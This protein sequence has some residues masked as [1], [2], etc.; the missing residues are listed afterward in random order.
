MDM[1]E[2][3]LYFSCA[4][5]AHTDGDNKG[6]NDMYIFDTNGTYIPAVLR[7]A[8]NTFRHEHTDVIRCRY[9]CL[10]ANVGFLAPKFT[11]LNLQHQPYQKVYGVC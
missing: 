8:F 4:A 2:V 5:K 10:L 1:L 11:A 7:F 3:R 9:L 6:W